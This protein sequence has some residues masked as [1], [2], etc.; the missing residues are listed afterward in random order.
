MCP[1]NK[2]QDHNYLDEIAEQLDWL[3]HMQLHNQATCLIQF[4]QAI[5]AG[6]AV[7]YIM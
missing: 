4:W 3:G 6:D 2:D 7:L 1:R 5:H